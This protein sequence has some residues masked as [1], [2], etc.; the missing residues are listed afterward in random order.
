MSGIKEGDV[1]KLKGVE[2][3]HTCSSDIQVSDRLI[4]DLSPKP[5]D[6]LLG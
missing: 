3:I 4:G 2:T 5:L 6:K 1:E